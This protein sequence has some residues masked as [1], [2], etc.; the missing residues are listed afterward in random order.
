MSVDGEFETAPKKLKK[1]RARCR[2]CKDIIESTH[3]HDFKFC[4]CGEIFV[5]GGLSYLRRG[6]N[7]FA[8]LEEL[9]FNEGE[10]DPIVKLIGVLE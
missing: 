1:N 2:K 3:D 9:S 7:S 6:A 5:D 10:E 4:T 8:N